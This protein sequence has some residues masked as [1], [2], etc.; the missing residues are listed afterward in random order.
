MDILG[1]LK[2]L[3]GNN[4]KEGYVKRWTTETLHKRVVRL[5]N[6]QK[7]VVACLDSGNVSK[8]LKKLEIIIESGSVD[9]T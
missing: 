4:R 3:E 8:A 5:K 6:K 9:E 7:H 2:V 1:K